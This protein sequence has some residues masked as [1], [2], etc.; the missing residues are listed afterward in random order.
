M[1]YRKTHSHFHSDLLALKATLAASKENTEPQWERDR[2]LG[3]LSSLCC[4][5]QEA[6]NPTKRPDTVDLDSLLPAH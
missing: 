4:P 6:G 3:S 2:G 5:V 1:T